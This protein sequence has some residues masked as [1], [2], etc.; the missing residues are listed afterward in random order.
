MLY[1]WIIY[2]KLYQWKKRQVETNLSV[3][4]IY[5]CMYMSF[6]YYYISW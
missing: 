3:Y 5:L 1:Q 2:L 6:Y 4:T